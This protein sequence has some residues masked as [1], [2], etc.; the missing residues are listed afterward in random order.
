MTDERV[1][2]GAGPADRRPPTWARILLRVGLLIALLGLLAGSAWLLG[3]WSPDRLRGLVAPAGPLAPA[4]FVG[5]FVVLNSAG[6]PA[7]LLGAAGGLTLGLIP[8]ALATLAGMTVAACVQFLL[9]RRLTGPAMAAA[10]FSGADRLR[11]ALQRRGWLAVVVLRLV[12]GPFVALNL[13][14]GLTPLRLR[15]MA[16]GTLIGGAPKALGWA[17]LSLGATRLAVSP[18]V[19]AAVV[20][21]GVALTVVWLLWRRPRSSQAHAQPAAGVAEPVDL[22]LDR[23]VDPLHVACADS[24]PQ[25]Q[26]QWEGDEGDDL[27]R[28]SRG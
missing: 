17:A 21:A 20:V 11:E 15:W 14:A 25:P 8:G 1:P 7:P 2:A 10:R 3:P 26:G 19:I 22:Y 27:V 6:V 16:I 23:P 24:C 13:A 12:P 9:A 18:L 4:V 28:D 5:L